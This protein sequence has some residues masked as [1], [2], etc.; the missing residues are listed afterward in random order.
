MEAL[1]GDG[2]PLLRPSDGS[3]LAPSAV[4]EALAR[5]LA[6]GAFRASARRKRLL[7]YLVEETVA[8][9][10]D[11]LKPYAIAVDA[12]GCDETFDPQADPI[13]RLEVGRLRRDLEHYYLTD[14][15]DDPL[16][17]TIPKGGYVPAFE[18]WGLAPEAAPAGRR[19][20]RR[21]ALDRPPAGAGS[22]R[23]RCCWCWRSGS[24]APAAAH[25]GRR[26]HAADGAGVGPAVLVLP[27]EAC[28]RR[29]RPAAG[30]RPHRRADRHLMRFDAL[31]VFAG[32]PPDQGQRERC[33]RPRPERPAY[34]VAG[35][36]RSGNRGG[37]GS[38]RA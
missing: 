24:P 32:A 15:R 34:V 33:R 28:R 21:D 18:R 31:Q 11:R 7:G 6:S 5:V 10:A 22:R 20:P 17:I 8:G 3:A 36:R 1:G 27:F 16:R 30:E 2:A 13:V 25:P 38:R 9:R 29:R 19:D 4:L 26:H 37:S 12:L 35:R 14:G 23:R